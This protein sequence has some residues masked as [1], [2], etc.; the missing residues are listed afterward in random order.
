MVRPPFPGVRAWIALA[1]LAGFACQPEFAERSSAVTGLRFLAVRSEPPELQPRAMAPMVN[2]RALLVDAAGPR[3]DVVLDWAFCT[4][5]KPVSELNDVSQACLA[6]QGDGIL[7]LDGTG[8]TATGPL[9][10]NGCRQF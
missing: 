1:A 8:L 10:A 5:P 6:R 3:D 4:E 7:P 9:P 2:Y